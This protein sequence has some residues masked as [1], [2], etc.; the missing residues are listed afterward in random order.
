VLEQPNNVLEFSYS[1]PLNTW[2]HIAVVAS[3]TGTN[4]YVN[5]NLTQSL[6]AFTL[7]TSATAQVRIGLAGDGQDPML[8]LVDNL[9]IYNRALNQSEVQTDLNTPA[10]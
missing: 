7:G 3:S 9:R 10:K 8:G 4:L 5:G 1:P 2:T 6:G